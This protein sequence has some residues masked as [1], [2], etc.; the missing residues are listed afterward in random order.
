MPNEGRKV[1]GFAQCDD[2]VALPQRI[3]D[4]VPL[5]EVSLAPETED[6]YA[7]MQCFEMLDAL[8]D[9]VRGFRDFYLLGAEAQ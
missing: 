2:D 9:E 1:S 7:H 4:F 3:V 5:V 8:S 6:V